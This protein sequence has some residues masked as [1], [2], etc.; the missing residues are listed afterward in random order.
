MAAKMP[1]YERNPPIF[2]NPELSLSGVDVIVNMIE[3]A[4]MKR[5]E[6]VGLGP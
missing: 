3:P 2:A 5:S 4:S 6:K 1:T